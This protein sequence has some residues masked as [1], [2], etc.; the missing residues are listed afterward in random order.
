MWE[1][2]TRAM[3]GCTCTPI[4]LHCIN[5]LRETVEASCKEFIVN[6][7]MYPRPFED[8][9]VDTSID[10]Q[11]MVK[12]KIHFFKYASEG[13]HNVHSDIKYKKKFKI[14]KRLLKQLK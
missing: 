10:L 2:D 8:Y 7:F 11:Y 13:Q 5:C 6:H 3:K 4:K 9:L 14:V 12:E 1:S